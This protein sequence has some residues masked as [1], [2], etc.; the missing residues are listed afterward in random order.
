M[1]DRIINM[2]TALYDILV[3]ELGS[4][5][6]WEHIK[7]QIGMFCYTGLTPEQ[8]AKLTNEHHIY[9]TKDGR[10]SVAGESSSTGCCTSM[11]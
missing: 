6:N 11:C 7:N 3:K 4:T 8:V 10:I 9:L 2:R 5:K 1:A